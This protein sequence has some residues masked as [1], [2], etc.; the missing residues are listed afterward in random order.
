MGTGPHENIIHLVLA[1]L[2]GAPEGTKGISLLQYRSFLLR[3]M[4]RLVRER[5]HCLSLE[6][7]LGIHAGPTVM[8]YGEDKGAV[9]C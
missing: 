4:V 1:R 3:M 7:K 5:V 6:E 2:P 8:S 9:G